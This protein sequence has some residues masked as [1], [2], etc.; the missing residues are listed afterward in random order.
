[1][2]DQIITHFCKHN[3][4]SKKQSGFR[5]GHSTQDVL[6]HVS[7][8]FLTAIDSG[9][10]VGAVFLDLAKAFDCVNH[11]IYCRNYLVMVSM[12]MLFPG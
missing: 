6:L 5:Y 3:L 1:V 11:D 4:F 12:V 2:S 7:D 9:H 8:S 10:Y